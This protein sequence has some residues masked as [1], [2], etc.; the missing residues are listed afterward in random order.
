MKTQFMKMKMFRLHL[1]ELYKFIQFFN[2][3]TFNDFSEVLKH[4]GTRLLVLNHL[5]NV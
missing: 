3:F 4:G 2:I 1:H 5:H